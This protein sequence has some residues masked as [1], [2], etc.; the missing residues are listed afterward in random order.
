MGKNILT[1]NLGG[2][3]Y[4]YSKF[5]TGDKR[6]EKRGTAVKKN[7]GR[8]MDDNKSCTGCGFDQLSDIYDQPFYQGADGTEAVRGDTAGK[9]RYSDREYRE[10]D[11]D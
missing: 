4:N 2:G 3:G 9:C 7:T 11:G 5:V 6:Y 8:K 10:S 1:I